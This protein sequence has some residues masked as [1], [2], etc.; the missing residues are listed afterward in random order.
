MTEAR[1]VEMADSPRALDDAAHAR[2]DNFR[3]TPRDEDRSFVRI[4]ESD[5]GHEPRHDLAA[6]H[7]LRS[8]RD[9]GLA[10]LSAAIDAGWWYQLRSATRFPP[11][12]GPPLNAMLENAR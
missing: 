7:A 1:A 2:P 3:A 11:T 8:D 9:A 5:E 12:C 10:W 4:A 6:V